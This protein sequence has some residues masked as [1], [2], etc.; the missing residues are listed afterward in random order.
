MPPASGSGPA[1]LRAPDRGRA[2]RERPLALPKRQSRRQGSCGGSG[3]QLPC[4]EVWIGELTAPYNSC[5]QTE[6]PVLWL[7]ETL[8]TFDV[9][10]RVCVTPCNDGWLGGVEFV[11]TDW[12]G[13]P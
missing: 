5:L 3:P 1:G 12:G 8:F 6:A 10:M 7:V 9:T 13:A 4:Q 2:S 11:K